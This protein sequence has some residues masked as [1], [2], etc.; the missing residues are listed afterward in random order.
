MCDSP[1]FIQVSCPPV[2]TEFLCVA[3]NTFPTTFQSSV[4]GSA[5]VGFCGLLYMILLY[6]EMLEYTRCLI[7]IN[8]LKERRMERKKERWGERR[9]RGKEG[10]KKIREYRLWFS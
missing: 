9:E 1:G 7:N 8:P 10:R 5:Y 3:L 4:H 2:H 6:S